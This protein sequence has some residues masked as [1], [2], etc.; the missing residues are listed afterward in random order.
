MLVFKFVTQKPELAHSRTAADFNKFVGVKPERLGL[1]SRLYPHL[2][3]SYLTEGLMNVWYNDSKANKFKRINSLVY[4]WD[5]DVNFIDRIEFAETPTHL[6]GQEYLVKFTRRYYEKFDTFKIDGSRQ[7][8]I[9]LREPVRATDGT[10][11]YVCQ[12]ITS[13]YSS[14]LDLNKC[15]AGMATM[16]V[17]NYHP[18]YHSEGYTKFQSNVERHRNYISL[19]R[20]DIS[21]SSHYAAM[22]DVYIS[23]SKTDEKGCKE[24]LIKMSKA[25]KDVLDS[26]LLARNNGM[27]FGKCNYDANGKCMI[28]DEKGRDIPMGR[29]VAHFN[30]KLSIK[31]GEFRGFLQ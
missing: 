18:E 30:V 4:E 8:M 14:T 23:A 28:T 6:I 29:L 1:M 22:E 3:A 9:V 27:L 11:E 21:Y 10:F 24:A 13:D 7:M 16:F 25:E 19:H 12:L 17:S 2:T 20:N 26:F 5:V 15:Q 31:F